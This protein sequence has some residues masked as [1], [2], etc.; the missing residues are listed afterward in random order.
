MAIFHMKIQNILR[1]EG[2][3]VVA[4]AAY[5]SAV[6]LTDQWTGLT[7][8][9]SKKGWVAY[10]R[11]FLPS[12]APEEY[13]D[14]EILLNAIQQSEKSIDAR[15]AREIEI[16]LPAELTLEQQIQLVEEFVQHTF[17]D[18]GMC[19]SVAI[20]N[21]PV[22]DDLGRAL[23]SAGNPTQN[24]GKMQFVNPHAHILLT[25]R[26]L[27]QKG[28][29]MAKTQIEY[30]CVKDGVEKGFTASEFASAK[31]EG[32]EKQYRYYE[33]D[34]KVWLP[35]SIAEEKGLTRVN[36][37]PR[38]TVHGRENE[39]T[40]R[41]NSVD[42]TYHWRQAWQDTCNKYLRLAGSSEQIDA[43]SFADQ[44]RTNEIPTVHLGPSAT[45]EQRRREQQKREGTDKGSNDSYK[46]GM[47]EDIRNH[48]QTARAYQ[49]TEEV[50][51]KKIADV[52]WELKCIE[53]DILQNT[54]ALIELPDEN[55]SEEV[56]R[57]KELKRSLLTV[58]TVFKLN[59]VSVMLII[60][61]YDQCL[62]TVQKKETG[63]LQENIRKEKAK[64][65][66][67]NRYQKQVLARSGFASAQACQKAYADS[68]ITAN[69]YR[70]RR[71][72]LMEKKADLKNRFEEIREEIPEEYVEKVEKLSG[73]SLQKKTVEKDKKMQIKGISRKK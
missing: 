17:V 68:T 10:T 47:N 4:A 30:R 1:S 58:D 69:A 11:V 46:D 57:E 53:N 27:D 54:R 16:A 45:Q 6:K 63:R 37:T 72:D 52:S 21:P 13:L 5:R 62:K 50:V 65:Q 42:T 67:R 14:Q 15:T 40:A 39:I 48:N 44:G 70:T 2:R 32:W 41:W 60:I 35:P 55:D 25:V 19:A 3:S 61:L 43:R 24:L 22:K 18:D 73:S 71:Q 34:T 28:K 64:M 51:T 33:G 8:D 36:K 23:D 26:P 66:E 9:Y 38:T 56:R 20:H 59:M 49:K 31:L 29:W 12:Q 7:Y